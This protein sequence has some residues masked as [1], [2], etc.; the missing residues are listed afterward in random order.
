MKAI[1]LILGLFLSLQ[2]KA[3]EGRC[4][5]TLFEV[6]QIINQQFTQLDTGAI[7]ACFEGKWGSI[8]IEKDKP[9]IVAG[10]AWEACPQDTGAI[11]VRKKGAADQ[12]ELTCTDGKLKADKFT[13]L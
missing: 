12:G 1:I 6:T 3:E 8:T 13:T 4:G 9:F 5:E 11:L 2:A 10:A 7:A